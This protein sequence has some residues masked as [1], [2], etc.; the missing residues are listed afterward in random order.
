[1]KPNSIKS[2]SALAAA[3]AAARRAARANTR[4]PEWMGS[5]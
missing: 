5:S 2:V 3:I 1:M 4:Y